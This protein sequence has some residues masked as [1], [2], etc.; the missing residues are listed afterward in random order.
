MTAPTIADAVARA[1]V[2]LPDGRT[3]RLLYL[4]GGTRPGR[5]SKGNRARVQLPSGT[6]LSVDPATLEMGWPA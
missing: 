5:R 4:P 6:V 3:G 2:R 1:F